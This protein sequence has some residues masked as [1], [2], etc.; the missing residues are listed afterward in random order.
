MATLNLVKTDDG[1]LFLQGAGD[2]SRNADFSLFDLDGE[3]GDPFN[4]GSREWSIVELPQIPN[5]VRYAVS[6]SDSFHDAR[7]E[8]LKA[9]LATGA[10]LPAYVLE[11]AG[12]N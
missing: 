2:P 7:I 1:K 9:Y 5:G 11:S 6:D 10:Y 4:L 12:L 8:I 3:G